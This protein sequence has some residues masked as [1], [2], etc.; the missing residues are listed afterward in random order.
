MLNE[1]LWKNRILVVSGDATF[2]SKQKDILD[3]ATDGI[4]DRDMV[5]LG[6]DKQ[7]EPYNKW[8]D[9][10][11][12]QI[13]KE[14]NLKSDDRVILFGKDGTIKAKWSEPVSFKEV[15]ELIDAMPMRKAEMRR[16]KGGE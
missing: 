11:L 1:F 12:D 16:R 13:S 14:F 5:I 6:F 3:Q 4:I 8:K 2:K 9:T 10:K 15:F 7:E